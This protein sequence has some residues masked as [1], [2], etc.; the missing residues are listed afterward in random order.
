MFRE[1]E[2]TGLRAGARPPVASGLLPVPRMNTNDLD[3]K[4]G[5][6]V[7]TMKVVPRPLNRQHATRRCSRI[8]RAEQIYISSEPIS[9]G[10]PRETIQIIPIMENGR[11]KALKAVCSCGSESTYDIQYAESEE[12]SS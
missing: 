7:N 6:F 9:V 1:A 10:T 3:L 2:R 5:G 4:N 8:L 11:I 12:T